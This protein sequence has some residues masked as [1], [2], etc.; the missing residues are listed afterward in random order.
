MGD[1]LE[2][3]MLGFISSILPA[4]NSICEKLKE[5]SKTDYFFQDTIKS[6]HGAYKKL[7]VFEIP[8]CRKRCVC[9]IGQNR[10]AETCHICDE[11]NDSIFNQIIYYYPFSDRISKTLLSD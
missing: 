10:G 5:T 7:R 11:I 2:S 3:V 8:V 1:G 6:G 9:F 4:G